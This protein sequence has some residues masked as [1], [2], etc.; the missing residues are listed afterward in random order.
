MLLVKATVVAG[1]LSYT[2]NTGSTLVYP[3]WGMTVKVSVMLENG[4]GFCEVHV[5]IMAG[6]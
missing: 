1:T 6:C 2:L 3:S 5:N 4:D